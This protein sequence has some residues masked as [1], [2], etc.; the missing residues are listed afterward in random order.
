MMAASTPRRSAAVMVTSAASVGGAADVEQGVVAADGAVLRHV[1]AGLA[2]EPDGGA[3]GGKAEAGAKETA[4]TGGG[5][6]F[7]LENRGGGRGLGRRV[8]CPIGCNG[9]SVWGRRSI[10]TIESSGSGQR[11]SFDAI[12]PWGGG[13]T[14]QR[15]VLKLTQRVGLPTLRA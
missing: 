9:V 12:G 15:I 2:E 8:R 4:A 13:C 5:S 6:R 11:R 10:L 1:A 7:R 3:V 14:V